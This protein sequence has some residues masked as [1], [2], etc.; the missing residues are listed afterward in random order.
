MIEKL[1]FLYRCHIPVK[2]KKK[3]NGHAKCDII[4]SSWFLPYI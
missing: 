1:A 3:K 4:L 2:L